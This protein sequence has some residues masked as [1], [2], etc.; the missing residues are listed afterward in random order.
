VKPKA[1]RLIAPRGK[2]PI[3]TRRTHLVRK[4]EPQKSCQAPLSPNQQTNPFRISH[5]NEKIKHQ[6]VPIDSTRFA[7]LKSI[8]KNNSRTRSFWFFFLNQSFAGTTP[9]VWDFSPSVQT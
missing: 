4:L 6:K 5:L 2:D 8:E 9:K 7:K 1:E 3:Q